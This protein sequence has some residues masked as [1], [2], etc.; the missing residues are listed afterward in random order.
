MISVIGSLYDIFAN[1]VHIIT[2]HIPPTI[3]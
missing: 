1:L 3:C 2:L